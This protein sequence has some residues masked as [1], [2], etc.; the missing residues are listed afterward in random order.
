[1]PSNCL[2]TTHPKLTCQ[3]HAKNKLK[4]T[5]ITAGYNKKVW[6]ECNYG[7]IWESAVVNRTAKGNN[8]PYCDGKKADLI[9]NL[10]KLHPHLLQ[11]WDYD[12]NDISP[13]FLLPASHRKVWW[14]CQIDSSHKWSATP[15]NRTI[16]KSQCPYCN[17]SSGERV[18]KNYLIDNNIKFS[19]QYRIPDCK[20]KR[21]LPFD[22]AVHLNNN[23]VL[24]EFQGLQHY[25]PINLYGGKDNFEKQKINDSIKRNYCYEN[26]ITLI[27]VKYNQIKD[28]PKLFQFMQ[29]S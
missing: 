23:I 11:E 10:A 25:E 28:I 29:K 1:V 21:S 2:A 13:E 20:N 7:H 4:P 18:I 9:N 14:K 3:W 15:L 6:W 12:K 19:R 5:E 26:N 27:E 17:S 8:C 22:F 24:I 16:K